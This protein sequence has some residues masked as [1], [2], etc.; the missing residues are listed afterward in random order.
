MSR[1]GVLFHYRV[2]SGLMH[3][4]L[5]GARKYTKVQ[6]MR[7]S[8]TSKKRDLGVTSSNV[9][10]VAVL[11]P[12]SDAAQP[13]A[14]AEGS[15]SAVSQLLTAFLS[16]SSGASVMGAPYGDGASGGGGTA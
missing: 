13:A 16:G 11:V 5:S 2:V 8:M 6:K 3:L 1:P 12:R 9:L 14:V 4:A 10:V 7:P 15:S